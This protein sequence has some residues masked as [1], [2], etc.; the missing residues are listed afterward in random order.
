MKEISNGIQHTQA[1]L[2]LGIITM[3]IE[4]FSYP[5]DLKA[6][7][8]KIDRWAKAASK[9]TKQK[10]LSQGA[11]RDLE[12][13]VATFCVALN[14]NSK[15]LTRTA[16]IAWWT[17]WPLALDAFSVCSNYASGKEW[18]YLVQTIETICKQFLKEYPE[19]EILGTELYE[20]I[21]LC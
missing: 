1:V 19:V 4:F 2:A 16:G 6:Q 8:D 5:K 17:A 14:E 21:T 9:K 18:R 15:D 7:I 10:A 11:K 12:K 13:V 20:Q 3:N